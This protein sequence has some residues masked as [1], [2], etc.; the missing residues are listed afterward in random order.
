MQIA[1]L[2]PQDAARV[3]ALHMAGIGTGFLSTLPRGFLARLY[4][5]IA[6]D[7]QSVVLVS[8]S[9][10]LNVSTPLTGF[11]AGTLDTSALYRR[12]I[13][14]EW[15]WFSLALA[16][17]AVS[18]ATVR[19]ILETIRYGRGATQ[20]AGGPSAELLS[21]AVAESSRKSGV[22]RALVRAFEQHLC[23]FEP[24]IAEY[25]VVTLSTDSVSNGFYASC[26]FTDARSFTHH[27]NPMREYRKRLCH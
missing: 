8:S 15:F 7:P 10:H 14:R 12:I 23:T 16:P 6:A 9:Q 11:I 1:S 24:H 25:K 27:G 18:P 21:I 19:R 26:G 5:A 20:T 3:A 13:R 17:R 4:R 22:G 2:L